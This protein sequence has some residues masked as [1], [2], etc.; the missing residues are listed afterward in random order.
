MCLVHSQLEAAWSITNIAS[1][2]TQHAQA[3]VEAG[4]LPPLV[5]LL[6]SPSIAV[7]EQVRDAGRSVVSAVR[8]L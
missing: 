2:T 4:A 1:G 6:A 5:A 8:G 3:A 7:R